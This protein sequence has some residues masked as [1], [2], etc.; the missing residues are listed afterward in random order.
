VFD[1][2]YLNGL[3]AIRKADTTLIQPLGLNLF[4][5]LVAL[6]DEFKKELSSNADKKRLEKP[7]L[8][9]KY[10]QNEIKN[11]LVTHHI[12]KERK[13]QIESLYNFSDENL[14]KL[15]DKEKELADLKQLNIQDKI[16]LKDIDRKDIDDVKKHIED[17]HKKISIFF[18]S[19]EKELKLLSYSK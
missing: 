12:D 18:T 17:S 8:D 4:S 13:K 3:L 9:L 2:S 5:Y 16:K 19:I 15:K 7:T 10:L 11:C 1:Y 6:I 14:K